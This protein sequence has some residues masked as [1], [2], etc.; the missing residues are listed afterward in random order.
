MHRLHGRIRPYAWGS[1]TAIPELLGVPSDGAPQAELWLGAHPSDPARLDGPDGP[2]LDDV[3][4]AAPDHWLGAS[5]SARFGPRLPY[6]L[7]VLAAAAPLSLQV[8]PD[9]AQARAGFAAEERAG[10]PV[11]APTRRYR[12]PHHKPEMIFALTPFEALTGFRPPADS[13]RALE[14]LP[15]TA[16][17][18]L[19]RTLSGG[20]PAEALRDAVDWLLCGDPQ[21]AAVP[22]ELAEG[23][24]ERGAAASAASPLAASD[25]DRLVARLSARHPADPG[26]GVAALMHHVLLEPGEA[27]FLGAGNLHAYLEGTGLE[28]MASSDNVLRG[29]LTPKHIDVPELLDVVDFTPRPVPRVTPVGSGP[30]RTFAPGTEEFRLT[31]VDLDGAVVAPERSGARLVLCLEGPVLCRASGDELL[32]ERGDAAVLADGDG[33][34]ELS[35][36]GTA[37]VAAVRASA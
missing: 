15:G 25:L 5:V 35:G 13:L 29:G 27:L 3:I 23:C 17:A 8:H 21:S 37:A 10:V 30:V 2:P 24:R 16:V 19:R 20:G 31:V 36:K 26:I 7:K 28:L 22:V 14:G 34:L 4:A 9:E 12:D 33:V 11:D 32:L 1:A 18:R 6:L